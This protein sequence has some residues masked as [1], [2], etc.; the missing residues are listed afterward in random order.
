MPN[1]ASLDMQHEWFEGIAGIDADYDFAA[2]LAKL[3]EAQAAINLLYLE[4]HPGIRP[5]YETGIKYIAEPPQPMRMLGIPSMVAKGGSDCKNLVAWRLA[6]LW[7][8]ELKQAPTGYGKVISHCKVYWRPD[9]RT[10]HAE[11][12]LP[13]WLPS[14]KQNH[15]TAEDPSRYLGM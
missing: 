4:R 13:P 5:M 3:A 2:C 11:I 1:V 6:E 8:D 12:R 9:T 7:R 10:F 15:E 14:G